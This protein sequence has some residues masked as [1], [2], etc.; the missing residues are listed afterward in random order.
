MAGLRTVGVDVPKFP[1]SPELYNSLARSIGHG[2]LSFLPAETMGG[3]KG[4]SSISFIAGEDLS[5][6]WE[7]EV[8]GAGHDQGLG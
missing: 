8:E 6:S 2:A 3:F 4:Q 5:L 7:A 1:C